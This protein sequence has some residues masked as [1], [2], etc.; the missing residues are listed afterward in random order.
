MLYPFLKYACYAIVVY[1]SYVLYSNSSIINSSELHLQNML[2]NEQY[3]LNDVKIERIDSYGIFTVNNTNINNSGQE[4]YG[5]YLS[6][7]D[8]MFINELKKNYTFDITYYD[9]YSLI[10]YI[11][12]SGLFLIF[13]IFISI[14]QIGSNISKFVKG[15]V[16]DLKEIL[17]LSNN[18][19]SDLI[20]SGNSKS[21]K[22]TKTIK[23]GSMFDNLL[24]INKMDMEIYDGVTNILKTRMKDVIGQVEAKHQVQKYINILK[25]HETYLDAGAKLPKGLLFCGPP[26]CGKTLMAKAIAG[27]SGVNF[28][29]MTGSDFDEKYVGVGSSRV[30]QLFQK[31]RELSPCIIF[32]DEID[33]IGM[34]RNTEKNHGYET[35]NKLLSE[36]DGIKSNENIMVIGATNHVSVLDQAL[37]RSGRF[38]T[39]I[40]IEFPILDERIEL[41]KYYVNKIDKNYLMMSSYNFEEYAKL[42]TGSSG[43]DIANICNHAIIDTIEKNKSRITNIQIRKS[44]EDVLFGIEKKSRKVKNNEIEITAYHEIGHALIGYMLKEHESPLTVSIIPRST[45]I[46]GYTYLPKNDDCMVSKHQMIAEIC[47][48][49]AGRIAEMNKFDGM[50]TTGA[51]NDFERATE[52]AKNMIVKYGMNENFGYMTY[53]LNHNSKNCVSDI[54]RSTIEN[55]IKMILDDCYN[56]TDK[57]IKDNMNELDILSKNLIEHETISYQNI[58]ELIPLYE[59]TVEIKDKFIY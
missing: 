59:N 51:S 28:I 33:S 27:E 30:K 17:T 31:A 24:G 20:M 26:G 11:P 40:H 21:T 58:C 49:L 15:F 54:N 52:I 9:R 23:G 13:M 16:I 12:F 18:S 41:F 48:L 22:L 35:L 55:K 39:K 43:A 46:A 3:I 53:E 45:G 4:Y 47:C 42:T 1:Y 14:L 34:K 7:N 37:T 5:F 29:S 6:K 25:N 10:E 38:D 36:F 50:M 32:I 8:N 19:E 57:I 2:S 44:I 56:F